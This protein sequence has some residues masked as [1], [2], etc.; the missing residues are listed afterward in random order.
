[1]A[2]FPA[3]SNLINSKK[4]TRKKKSRNTQGETRTRQQPNS[5]PFSPSR[6]IASKR[7]AKLLAPAASGA[8]VFTNLRG[9]EMIEIRPKLNGFV[10]FQLHPLRFR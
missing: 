6:D 8:Q 10:C 7:P 1:M 4:G 9:S 2:S 3:I 5:E